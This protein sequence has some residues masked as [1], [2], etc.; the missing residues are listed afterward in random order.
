MNDLE[1]YYASPILRKFKQKNIILDSLKTAQDRSALIMRWH[2]RGGVLITSYEMFRRMIGKVESKSRTPT[3]TPKVIESM[4]KCLANPG[5]D[6]IVFDEGHK[7]QNPNTKDYKILNGVFTKRRVILTGTPL[8]NNLMEYYHMISFAVPDILG[9]KK[10]FKSRFVEPIKTWTEMP[11]QANK[12]LIMRRVYILQRTLQDCLQ[13]K[14]NAVNVDELPA[15]EEY[16]VYVRLTEL[17][18]KIYEVV[19]LFFHPFALL[20]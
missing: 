14:T 15:K 17:Q 20:D 9:T 2:N 16:V 8:Q 1:F 6:L 11:S 10:Q 7:L 13:R 4:I 5:S 19:L 3:L 12:T 18:M